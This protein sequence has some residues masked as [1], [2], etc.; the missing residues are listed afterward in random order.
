MK[1]KSAPRVLRDRERIKL[2]RK[3]YKTI[4]RPSM[5]YDIEC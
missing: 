4:I 5:L 1:W 3:F 2:K